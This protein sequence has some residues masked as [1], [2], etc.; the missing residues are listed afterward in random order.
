M[1]PQ[2]QTLLALSRLSP[3]RQS[4]TGPSSWDSSRPRKAAVPLG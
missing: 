3:G 2:Q 4:L 1:L